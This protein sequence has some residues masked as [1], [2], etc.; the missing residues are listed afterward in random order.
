VNTFL[1]DACGKG[2]WVMTGAHVS[3]VLTEERDRDT[4]QT[5]EKTG[6]QKRVVGVLVAVECF[7]TLQKGKGNQARNATLKFVIAAP[8]VVCCAGA[9]HTPAL[10]LRSGITC[11][12]NVGSN[13]R[14]HPCAIVFGIFPPD[15]PI[16]CWEGPV[17]SKFSMEG[18]D[19]GETGYGALLFTPAAH[20][21]LFAAAAPW[22]GG[23]AFKD[24]FLKFPNAVAVLILV[25]DRGAGRVTLE[26][27]SGNPRLKYTMGCEDKAAMVKGM[28]LGLTAVAAAGA[29]E[30]M[31]L[32]TGYAVPGEDGLR[33]KILHGTGAAFEF[34]LFLKQVEEVGVPELGIPTFSAHQMGTA[35]LGTSPESS[36]LD[37][38]GECWDVAG[39]YAADAS[40]FPSPTGVNP[41]ITV[42][43]VAWMLAGRLAYKL[44]G[45]TVS[46]S[47]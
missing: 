21:G 9:L 7:N 22:H 31:T 2:A 16:K 8:T 6:R 5:E 19:W 34:Q 27:N 43:A 42:L 45:G 23:R 36:V 47:C 3:K 13:L 24:L 44:K 37:A 32:H 11:R 26:A 28:M 40:T 30:V 12:G 29:C 46:S 39:L 14:L 20:P 1:A 41:M 35:R 4:Q 10:L 25:R 17:M 18:G 38:D 15:K 33:H